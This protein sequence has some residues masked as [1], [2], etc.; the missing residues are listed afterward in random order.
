[1]NLC[2]CICSLDHHIVASGAEVHAWSLCAVHLLSSSLWVSACRLMSRCSNVTG[3]V[4]C[5]RSGVV[6]LESTRRSLASE[7]AARSVAGCLPWLTLLGI[8]SVYGCL[9][10]FSEESCSTVGV[11]SDPLVA[12]SRDHGLLAN[13]NRFGVDSTLLGVAVRRVVRVRGVT[14]R[15]VLASWR[16]VLTLCSSHVR[17]SACHW[18]SLSCTVG[19]GR[20]ELSWDR[21]CLLLHRSGL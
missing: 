9:L 7:A 12:R 1:M 21:C 15:R 4:E 11:N 5:A 16:L 19:H 18:V 3:S 8:K 2:L 10:R 20:A 17:C 13:Y 6:S 14:E